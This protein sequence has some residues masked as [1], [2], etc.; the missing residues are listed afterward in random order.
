MVELIHTSD[1]HLG[2]PFSA[3][4]GSQRE[5]LSAARFEA[6]ERLFTYAR[7]QGVR[8]VLCAGDQ[9]DNGELRDTKVLLRAFGVISSFPEIQVVMI[10]GNHDPYTPSSVYARVAAGS[11]P[12]NLMFVERPQVVELPDHGVRILA[13]PLTERHGRVNPIVDLC[14]GLGTGDGDRGAS[15]GGEDTAVIIGLAHGSAAVSERLGGDSDAFPIP[16][17]LAVEAGLDYLALGDWHSHLSLGERTYYPGTHEPL[18]FGDDAGSLHVGIEER[19]TIPTVKRIGS[20]IYRWE[21]LNRTLRDE[22][23]EEALAELGQSADGGSSVIRLVYDGFVSLEGYK[24]L[25]EQLTITEGIDFARFVERMPD[26][27]P[28]TD[29]LRAIASE[30]YMKQVVDKL[31]LLAED[32]DRKA[33][34]ALLRVYSYFSAASSG[35]KGGASSAK[36]QGKSR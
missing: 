21:E 36:R 3:F 24:R 33:D 12:K 19:G 22:N 11:Y 14:A 29:E 4:G 31:L 18:A 35:R 20:P 17:R 10:A 32:G 5:A 6:I 26:I 28:S 16:P 9:I 23:L 7:E 34:E 13:A 15:E 1:W 25:E 30:G 2:N 27:R 8:L